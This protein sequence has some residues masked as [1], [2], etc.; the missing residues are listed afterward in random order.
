MPPVRKVRLSGFG[1]ARVNNG[2]L[3]AIDFQAPR[4]GFYPR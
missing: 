1:Y 4:L 2:E 3:H